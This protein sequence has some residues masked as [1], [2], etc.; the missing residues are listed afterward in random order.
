MRRCCLLVLVLLSSIGW[1][2]NV[3][4]PKDFLGHDACEDYYLANYTELTNYWKAL[5]AKSNRLTVQSIGKT[6]EGK[7][8][9]MCIITDPSNR[10]NLE[11]IRKAN[12]RLAMA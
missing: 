1:A 7:D 9:L 5:A 10:R 2:S 3:P 6:E 4:S 11:G 8:Q 12:E